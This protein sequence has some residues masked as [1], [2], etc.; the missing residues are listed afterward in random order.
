M[1]REKF[2]PVLMQVPQKA[3][4]AEAIFMTV[5]TIVAAGLEEDFLKRCATD[6]RKMIISKDDMD[7]IKTY[8]ATHF[9]N[10]PS[11]A[12]ESILSPNLERIV[13]S[14]PQC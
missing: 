12:V 2:T 7:F 13:R 14:N 8:L 6:E 1:S 3:I 4:S 9:N 10:R 11:D 5:K